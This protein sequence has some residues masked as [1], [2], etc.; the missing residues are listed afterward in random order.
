MYLNNNVM[1]WTNYSSFSCLCLFF[2]IV[3]VLLSY[4]CGEKF[5]WVQ[6]LLQDMNNWTVTYKMLEALDSET[7]MEWTAT[8][9]RIYF[10]IPQNQVESRLNTENKGARH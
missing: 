6:L 5:C 8:L 10:C 4:I 9:L 7:E 1:F 2:L 3:G